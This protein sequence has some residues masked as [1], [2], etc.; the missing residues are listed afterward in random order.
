MIPTHRT[1][2][3]RVILRYHKTRIWQ[4]S[5]FYAICLLVTVGFSSCEIFHHHSAATYNKSIINAPFDVVIVPGLPYDSAKINPVFKARLLWA[6]ELYETGI[7]RNIIFSG[8]AVH[9][10]YI[11]SVIM[12]MMADSMGIPTQHTFIEDKALHS[13][14]NI[15]Y[16]VELAHKMNFKNIAVAT[17]PIQAIAIKKY[18]RKHHERVSLLPFNIKSMPLY[19]KAPMPLINPWNAFVENFV[20]LYLRENKFAPVQD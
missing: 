12:K 8:S 3:N 15:A 7:A 13:I 2:N 1:R 10:P 19:Y 4:Q 18:M 17:D 6:K 9:S 11:E 14:E 20:P 16:G 5:I